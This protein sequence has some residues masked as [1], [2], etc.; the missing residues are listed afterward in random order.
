MEI[1]KVYERLLTEFGRQFWWPAET[2]FEMMVGAILTQRTTWSAVEVA[3]RKLKRKKL[4]NPHAL[5]NSNPQLVEAMVRQTG[6]YRQK[7]R[8]I[9]K[10]A[11]HL[12]EGY[13]GSVD[14]FLRKPWQ[15]LRSELRSLEGVG[16]ET[17]DVILLYA[18]NQLVFPIDAYTQRFSRRFGLG[19]LD[20][21]GLK[22]HFEE[23]MPKDL[24]VYKELH[25]LIDELG[26]KYCK[27][28]PECPSC[29]L[30]DT[31]PK[32]LTDAIRPIST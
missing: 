21:E 23:Q 25:A 30:S 26:K 16:R 5:A 8:R 11:N 31:C 29:I 10:L 19:D 27:K 24:Q 1:V 18:A 20:Y 28:A 4:L 14:R 2:R 6:F 9:R 3:I 22:A 15:E 13:G 12:V 7:A 17:A 32:N